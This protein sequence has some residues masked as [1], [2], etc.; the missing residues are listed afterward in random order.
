MTIAY[1]SVLYRKPTGTR[2]V[3]YSLRR[4]QATS[5]QRKRPNNHVKVHTSKAGD[6]VSGPRLP[7]DKT[8]AHQMGAF[9]DQDTFFFP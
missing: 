3:R 9:A 4:I 1:S 2:L 7:A 6:R 5:V 8:L